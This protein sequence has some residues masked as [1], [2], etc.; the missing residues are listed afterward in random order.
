MRRL[1]PL[2]VGLALLAAGAPAEAQAGEVVLRRHA[3]LERLLTARRTASRQRTL[4]RLLEQAVDYDAIVQRALVV[5]WQDLEP[6]Q[7]E[8]VTDLLRRA[9]RAR[10]QANVEALAGY[11]VTLTTEAPRGIGVRVTTAA[12]RGDESRTIAYDVLNTRITDLIVDG[13][14]LVHQYRVQFDRVIRREGWSAFV[15]R[16]RQNVEGSAHPTG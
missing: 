6:A 12:R 9:I 3:Q 11:D 14:S 5:H 16:L 7:R 1:V 8:E 2:L 10:Y 15:A 13:E 4:D